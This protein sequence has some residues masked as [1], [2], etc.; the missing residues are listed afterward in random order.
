M[1]CNDLALTIMQLLTHP[2]AGCTEPHLASTLREKLTI[3]TLI[4]TVPR[5]TVQRTC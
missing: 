3:S 1:S 4:S 5:R 2:S